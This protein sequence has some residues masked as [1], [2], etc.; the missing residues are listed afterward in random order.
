MIN[1]IIFLLLCVFSQSAWTHQTKPA[2]TDI[3][4]KTQNTISIKIAANIEAIIAGIGPQHQD[5][6]D[7]PEAQLYNQLRS[8]PKQQLR[9]RFKQI[10]KQYLAKLGL[11]LSLPQTEYQALRLVIERIDIPAVGDTRLSRISHIYLT[12]NYQSLL[13][14]AVLNQLKQDAVLKAKWQ[15]PGEYGDSIVRFTSLDEKSQLIEQSKAVH[16][17]KDGQAS[18]DYPIK[19]PLPK[20]SFL[21]VMSQY[22]VLGFEHIIPKGLDHILFVLGLFLFSFKLGSLLWQVTAFTVAHSITLAM[23]VLGWVSLS[24]AIVEPLIALSISY[25]AIEN[26]VHQKMNPNRLVVIFVFG[27]LHGLGFAFMLMDLGLP[28]GQLFNALLSFNLGVELGQ[29]A[30]VL[31]A[32]LIFANLATKHPKAYRKFVVIPGS[33]LI[34]L[35][36]IYW[37]IERVFL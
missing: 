3:E 13:T 12:T 8:L 26:I 36:G 32:A 1:I 28:E 30:V 18:P 6:D 31:I 24:A 23:S 27:L 33:S 15:Y 11:S 25:V 21:E 35:I 5:T 16:W 10:E 37:T 2:I 34:A 4:F 9:E 22:I 17:L 20:A 19:M 7:A 14:S 29:L